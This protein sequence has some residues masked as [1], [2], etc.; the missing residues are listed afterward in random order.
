MNSQAGGTHQ[1]AI[2]VNL[3]REVFGTF[4]EIGA[5]QEVVRWFF[6]VGGASGTIAKTMSAYDMEVSDAIY[7]ACKRYVSRER[8]QGMLDYEWM[9]LMQRLD[10]SRGERTKFFVFADTVAARSFSRQEPGEGWL[11]I[12]FQ[13]APR[14]EPSEIIIHARLWDDDNVRQQEALGV[15]G[16]NLIHAAFYRHQEPLALIGSLL[17][18]LGRARMEVDM[19]KFSGPSFAGVDHRLMSL[20]LVDQRLTNAALFTARGDVVEPAEVLHKR[21]VLIE[22]GTFRPMTNVMLDMLERS[23][24]QMRHEPLL[25]G[26]EPLVLLEMTLRH[27]DE[28]SR[29]QQDTEDPGGKPGLDHTDFLARADTLS[30]FGKTVMI[31]NYARFHNVSDYLR[32]YTQKLIVMPVGAPILGELFAEK[33]YTDLEGGILEACGRLFHGPVKLYVYPRR[34]L[35]TGEFLGADTFRPREGMRHLYAHLRENRFI[36]PIAEYRF[37]DLDVL[38]KDVLQII[39]DGDPIWQTLVPPAV[40]ERIKRDRLFGFGRA[41]NGT[42]T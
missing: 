28:T 2:Q 36:E 17:D 35:T 25:E 24:A 23:E 8:L 34:N 13:T 4:A 31:S 3:D 12:R 18:D 42:P 9:R 7:G 19:I 27:L 26:E 15:L 10:K 20:Q 32:R 41:T 16:V 1:K 40:A 14:A 11:G 30:M 22:R 5:G 39:Q 37:A 29:A 6:Q 38:P 21:A 33:H